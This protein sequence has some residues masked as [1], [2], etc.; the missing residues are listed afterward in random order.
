MTRVAFSRK[1][2]L[3]GREC[4]YAGWE[5]RGHERKGGFRESEGV[6]DSPLP[7]QYPRD[8]FP[9]AEESERP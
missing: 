1:L 2:C 6:V 7:V 8:Y 3:C 9:L 5:R 4:L